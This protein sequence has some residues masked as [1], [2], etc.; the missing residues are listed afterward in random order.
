MYETTILKTLA[1]KQQRTVILKRW[2]AKEVCSVT[3]PAYRQKNLLAA[4]QVRGTQ[5]EPDGFL[6]LKGDQTPSLDG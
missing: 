6:E 5:T 2:E 4:V 1:I 3:A